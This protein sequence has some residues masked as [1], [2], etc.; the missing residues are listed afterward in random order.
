[1]TY[2][3]NSPN[4]EHPAV[5]FVPFPYFPQVARHRAHILVFIKFIFVFICVLIERSYSW[6]LWQQNKM[7]VHSL[8]THI[9]ERKERERRRD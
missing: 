9:S 5:C 8:G 1:M 3:G 4:L 2:S 7:M 6:D